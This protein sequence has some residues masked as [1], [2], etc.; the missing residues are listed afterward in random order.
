MKV[1]EV[2]RFEGLITR[3]GEE[4]DEERGRIWSGDKM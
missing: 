2:E 1:K 4:E 3:E